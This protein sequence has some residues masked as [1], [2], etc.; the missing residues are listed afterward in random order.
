MWAPNSFPSHVST[1]GQWLRLELFALWLSVGSAMQMHWHHC[2]SSW[3]PFRQKRVRMVAERRETDPASPGAQSASFWPCCW[4]KSQGHE[5]SGFQLVST[6]LG[7]QFKNLC[8]SLH[9]FEHWCL[10]QYL[11]KVRLGTPFGIC[12]RCFAWISSDCSALGEPWGQTAG[13]QIFVI[14]LNELGIGR[15]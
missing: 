14:Y 5:G 9:A 8:G 12:A 1:I 11:D 15:A 2:M 13:V 3:T 4:A 7:L 10:V 6:L